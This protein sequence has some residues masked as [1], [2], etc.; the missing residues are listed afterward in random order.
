[1]VLVRK[2]TG[3]ETVGSGWLLGGVPVSRR[4]AADE[5]FEVRVA[6][7]TVPVIPCI[8]MESGCQQGSPVPRGWALGAEPPLC[9][10]LWE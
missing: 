10:T 5:D 2:V 1:M 4:Q 3:W 7:V 6:A 9:S 8:I